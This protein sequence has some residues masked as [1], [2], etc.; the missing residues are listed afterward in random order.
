MPPDIELQRNQRSSARSGPS[1][2]PDPLSRDLLSTT[3]A[4]ASSNRPPSPASWTI[5]DSAMLSASV[6][7][8]LAVALYGGRG[9]IF[10]ED[11]ML[12]WMLLR[13]PSFHHMITSWLHG[14]DGGGISFYLTGRFWLKVFGTSVTAYRMYS[15]VCFAIGMTLCWICLRR[16]Y[17][18]AVVAFSMLSVWLLS[19]DLV[20]HM[21]EGRFY[22]LLV[23]A[24]AWG[25][26]LN[27]RSQDNATVSPRLYAAVFLCHFL[28]VTSQMLG[29]VFSGLLVLGMMGMD[30]SKKLWR[31]R[32]YAAAA[33]SWLALIPSLPAIRASAAVGKPHF[34][35]TQPHVMELIS[36]YTAFTPN[37][38]L[39]FALLLVF[40][41]VSL[42][43]PGTMQQILKGV[44][45]RRPVYLFLLLFSV[46]PV[47]FFLEGT[48]GP[49]L[50]IR[51]YLLPMVFLTTFA[52][53]ELVTLA[54]SLLPESIAS[55]S[56]ARAAGW[57]VFLAA[58]LAYD[59]GVTPRRTERR[60]D[61]TDAL[62]G[63]LPKGV[64]VICEDAYAFTEL[65]SLQHGSGVLYTYLLDWPNTLAAGTPRGE[66]TE[67]HLMENWKQVG[68]FS[69]SIEYADRF[70][71]QTPNFYTLSFQ[72]VLPQ[73][74]SGRRVTVSDR[75]S[76]SI[77][78]SGL[79]R[80]LA[81][82]PRFRVTLFKTVPLGEL[83]ASVWQVCRLG[84]AGCP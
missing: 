51:R 66:V 59:F 57:S 40:V 18:P 38:A 11:E 4:P 41:G 56:L 65:I 7:L 12:G 45:V 54:L 52:M 6:L 20:R 37:L 77:I 35:T 24:V 3:V 32:L 81:A 13:D 58:L 83:T 68:Y 50:A 84:S 23:A 15:Q 67:Y 63:N 42:R 5:L 73:G 36:D 78:G 60:T 62:S 71:S 55:S 33:L 46:I 69:G 26:W 53:A 31:P 61:Y 64:P 48:V 34:W 74:L 49:P 79:H 8:M 14:A 22:G 29:V 30:R 47:L 2:S 80:H 70:L 10:W 16:F 44:R 82:D 25:L 9:R 27:F 39:L 43:R 75:F 1:S 28:V 17:R 72:D 19:P 76:D 21:S